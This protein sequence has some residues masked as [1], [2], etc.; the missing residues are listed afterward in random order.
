M[1][2][3]KLRK[4]NILFVLIVV[5]ISVYLLR[6][7]VNFGADTSK[8]VK[9]IQTQEKLSTSD[10]ETQLETRKSLEITK[11]KKDGSVDS[12]AFFNDYVII[13]DSRVLGFSSYGFLP[14]TY[15]L[16][17]TGDT[18]LKLS[19][20]SDTL[21]KVNPK[22]IYIS[23]GA[24]DVANNL[25][26]SEGGYGAIYEKQVK[27]ILKVC[28][29]AN[30][31]VNSIIPFGQIAYQTEPILENYQEYNDELKKMC[32]KNGWTFI[33][34][35]EILDESLLQG[36]GIH[37]MADFYKVWASNMTENE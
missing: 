13:G 7:F 8:G 29:D 5:L 1:L 28:P 23:Y 11:A 10:I 16:A 24:N 9:Y 19:N 36:D 2:M 31:Y 33:D 37:F 26:A 6:R 22:H 17:N 25:N 34:N 12:F 32:K 14:D 20:W 15:V 4:W 3:K 18:V 27:K 30:I 35:S 21:K